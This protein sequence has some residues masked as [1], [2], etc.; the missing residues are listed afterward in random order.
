MSSQPLREAGL[1]QRQL[2]R[3]VQGADAGE[4][5]AVGR[6]DRLLH[7]RAAAR[8]QIPPRDNLA[9]KLPPLLGLHPQLGHHLHLLVRSVSSLSLT[10]LTPKTPN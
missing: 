5:A 4:L 3:L 7:R 1:A 8:W 6:R 2:D 10:R 9:P